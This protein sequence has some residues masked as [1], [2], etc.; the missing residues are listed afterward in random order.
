MKKQEISDEKM[1]VYK[2]IKIGQA[3]ILII[4]GILFVM[5]GILNRDTSD[6]SSIGMMLSISIGVIVTVYGLLDILSGYLLYR[7]P[8]NQDCLIG[9]VM[10]ALATVL[11]IKRTIINEILSYFVSI[12]MIIFALM[13]VLHG[14]DMIIGKGIKKSIP[15]AVFAFI[16]AG[17]MVALGI[18][19]LIFYIKDNGTIEIMML[20]VVGVILVMLGI[21]SLSII[22]IKIRNTNKMLK[23]Q[24]LEEEQ[25]NQRRIN[26]ND[27]PT[28][29][30]VKII[31]ISDLKKRPKG[32]SKNEEQ[33]LIVVEEDKDSTAVVPTEEDK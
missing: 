21:A 6:K 11:F 24:K 18:T 13:L 20:L 7:N 15:K 14:V 2:W 17:V 29:T 19:Y 1:D 28:N 9:E 3:A 22:I 25:E 5:T 33:S 31:D 16:L 32:S 30:D 10:L 27:H 8:Y 23:Q 26:E 12:F 4:L